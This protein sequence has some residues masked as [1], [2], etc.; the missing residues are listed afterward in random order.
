MPNAPLFPGEI[1]SSV[2]TFEPHMNAWVMLA[3]MDLVRNFPAGVAHPA[4]GRLYVCGGFDGRALSSSVEAYDPNT[5][6]WS[7]VPAMGK[8]RYDPRPSNSNPN[9]NRLP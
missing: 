8:G 5:G 2:E 1:L 3:P 7:Y 9:P 4:N 6:G